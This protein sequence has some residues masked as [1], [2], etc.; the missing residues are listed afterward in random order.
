MQPK[1]VVNGHDYT[2]YLAE[3]GLKPS[4]NDLDADG[5]GRDLINGLMYR[6]KIT[7]KLKWTVSFN[8]LTAAIMAQLQSDMDSEYVTV[9][10]LEPKT[11]AYNSRSYY[12]ST[13]NGGV[14]RHIGGVTYYD[15]ATFD[16][17]ER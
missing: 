12:C 9:T 2:M 5:S 3:D 17:T 13:I 10:M 15:G 4:K 8:R 11:N 14:Q 6:K 16:I 7:S 1:F